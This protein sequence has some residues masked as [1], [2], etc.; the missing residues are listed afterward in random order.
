MRRVW[1][2]NVVAGVF[3]GVIA[4][5]VSLNLERI[6]VHAASAPVRWLQAGAVTLVIP[7]LLVDFF[8][9]RSGHNF[10]VWLAAACNFVFWLGFAW[11][12]GFLVDKLRQQL[13]L[14]ASHF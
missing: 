9:S 6:A 8:C 3:L 7:G 4:A 2:K 13:R 12:F 11:L 5:A 1:N 14:F 10:P